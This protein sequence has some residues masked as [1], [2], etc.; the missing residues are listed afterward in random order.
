MTKLL[1]DFA[2]IW[3]INIKNN[4]YHYIEICDGIESIITKGLYNK[5][6]SST[7]REKEDDYLF[8]KLVRK[9]S[10]ITPKH[11]DIDETLIDKDYLDVAINSINKIKA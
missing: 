1:I 6:F 9:F 11:L 7:R 8:E 4:H 3:K 5:I 10:F 2:N